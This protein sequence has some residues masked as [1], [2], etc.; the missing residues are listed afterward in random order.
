MEIG[1]TYTV[2]PDESALINLFKML[3]ENKIVD[4]VLGFDVKKKRAELTPIAIEDPKK[5][6]LL[7]I[8]QYLIYNYTRV[9]SSSKFVH[10]KILRTMENG[11]PIYHRSKK[12]AL[13]ARP[14]DTRAFI[15]LSKFNQINLESL[16]IICTNCT[17]SISS[18]DVES[19]LKKMNIDAEKVE[20]E[21]LGLDVLK[22]LVDGKVQEIKLAKD[23]DRYANCNRCTK[24]EGSICDLQLDFYL[25]GTNKVTTLTIVS[26]KGKDIME[27][28]S[29]K[30]KLEK[31]AEANVKKRKDLMSK[32]VANAKETREKLIS[33]YQNLSDE[34]K[35][36][37]VKKEF[38]EACRVCGQCINACPVCYC[39]TCDV[40]RRRKEKEIGFDASLYLLTKMAH[41]GDICVG[42]GKCTVVCPAK[43]QSAFFYDVL[44]D[45]VQKVFGY[46]PGKSAEDIY[47]R[48]MKAIKKARSQS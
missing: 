15:E 20:A 48:T 34:E 3:L 26:E 37:K 4:T 13:I 45:Y 32:I 28:A 47:P 18:K 12:V 41:M 5:L 6:T 21:E 38:L 8:S 11:K 9:N 29:S 2:K 44:T 14:C 30:L 43:I 19:Q 25:D 10:T 36:Q 35:F 16:F 42:C 23:I 22:I 40:L 17:G 31:T 27:K 39:P 1:E 33:E 46:E 7:P 24:R